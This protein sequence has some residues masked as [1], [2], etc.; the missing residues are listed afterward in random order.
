MLPS[1]ES[2]YHIP[3]LLQE[4]LEGLSIYP[5]GR[6]VDVTFGGGG[7]SF[8]ILERLGASGKLIAFDRDIEAQRNMPEVDDNRLTL[9]QA[10]YAF[11]D[12]YLSYLKML[13]VD[14]ILADFGISFH[15][16][17]SGERGFSFRF[18][19]PLDMRMGEDTQLTAYQVIN[20]YPWERL[21]EIFSQYGE[22]KNAKTLAQHIDKQRRISKIKT[23]F[24]FARISEEVMPSKEVKS[25]YL[26]PVFQAIRMEVNQE[27]AHIESFLEQSYKSLKIGGRLVTLTY[28]SLED[29]I[30]KNFL[31]QKEVDTTPLYSTQVEKQWKLINKKPITPSKEEVDNNPRSRSAKLRV[32]E[33]IA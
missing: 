10:N 14:G 32:A 3:A 1:N 28:H 8:A 20:T 22:V 33:K 12:N 7:H 19:A 21:Q 27:L 24:Q 6:Y 5:E 4:C 26:A 18:D 25:K 23:T 2:I 17:D 13:P 15:Q 31:A 11:M 9:I 30:V 16:I 29:R